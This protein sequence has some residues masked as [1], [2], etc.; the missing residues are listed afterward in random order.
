MDSPPFRTYAWLLGAAFASLLAGCQG[1]DLTLPS[2]GSPSHLKVVSGNGQ[3]GTVGSDLPLPL[4]VQV[5]DRA[6]RKVA[7]VSLLFETK[8]P[9]ALVVPAEIATNDTGYAAVQVR[10]GSIEG[11]QTVEALVA[12]AAITGPRATF[13]LIAVATPPGD[14]DEGE[15]DGGDQGDNGGGGG[16]DNGQGGGG[17]VGKGGHGNGGGDDRGRGGRGHDNHDN[18]DDD[19]HGH[20]HHGHEHDDDADD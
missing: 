18:D 6:G 15:G 13:L 2:D 11:T 9:G 1:S 10:L 17:K 14:D 7:G 4:A 5:T 3:R 8:V 19:E 16:D 12:D 20:G